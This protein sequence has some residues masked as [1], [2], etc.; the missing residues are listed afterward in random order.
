M[1]TVAQPLSAVIDKLE[2][3]NLKYSVIITK[4]TRNVFPLE[5]KYYVIRQQLDADG[6]LNLIA[7]AKMGKEVF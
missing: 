5:D 2:R 3:S 1:N 6:I 4:P 7:A